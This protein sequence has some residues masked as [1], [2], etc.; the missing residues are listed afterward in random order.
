MKSKIIAV[1]LL[2]ALSLSACAPI[3]ED[4][5]S[6]KTTSVSRDLA[7]KFAL[8]VISERL[9]TPARSGFVLKGNLTD[10]GIS[11][12]SAEWELTPQ[13]DGTILACVIVTPEDK[14]DGSQSALVAMFDLSSNFSIGKGRLT[15]GE[16]GIETCKEAKEKLVEYDVNQ[17]IVS[18]DF[19]ID[20][21]VVKIAPYVMTDKG[22]RSYDSFTKNGNFFKSQL[23][24][25]ESSIAQIE[26]IA[27]FIKDGLKTKSLTGETTDGFQLTESQLT[28]SKT[29]DTIKIPLRMFVTYDKSQSTYCVSL[30]GWLLSSKNNTLHKRLCNEVEVY[31]SLVADYLVITKAISLLMPKD[32]IGYFSKINITED[33]SITL[34]PLKIESAQTTVL[35]KIK[36][37]PGF[38]ISA[39]GNIDTKGFWCL[40]I[41]NSSQYLVFN[42]SYIIPGALECPPS[43]P[44]V[45]IADKSVKPDASY[46]RP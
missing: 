36:L 34:L 25:D 41:K 42:Q 1:W 21:D 44:V 37:H 38:S 24:I 14:V 30:N 33:G 16:N 18:L 32:K 17:G 10:V 28:D 9:A 11:S 35:K 7:S 23:K 39:Q 40:E 29:K 45:E 5:A 15:F 22:K 43:V 4:V 12:T 3:S 26:T 2:L 19:L 8:Y 13:G 46:S 31:D 27:T 6:T 20:L